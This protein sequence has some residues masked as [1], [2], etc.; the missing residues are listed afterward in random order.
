MRNTRKEKD[1]YPEDINNKMKVL[2]FGVGSTGKR[3]YDEVKDYYEVVGFLDNE[4]QR[5]GEK[6]EDIEILGNANIVNELVY[7][8]IIVASLPGLYGIRDTL[9]ENG[10][11][12][13]KIDISFCQTQ[14]EARINFLNDYAK[15]KQPSNLAVAEGGVFQ[16]EFAK[17]INKNFPNADLYLFD[18]FEGFDKR[19]IA[20]ENENNFSN[21]PVGHTNNTS[22]ELVKEKLQFPE[23][24][25]FRKGFFP[26]TAQ[27]L[28]NIE[29]QFVNLDF[30]LFEPTLEGIRF[31]YPRMESK[32][33][34]LIHDYYN[35][36]YLG[37][38]KAIE[39]FEREIGYSLYKM[40]IGDHC[41]IAVIKE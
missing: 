16:G 12:V 28:E 39:Q 4:Q 26:E 21:Q 40:P 11:E 29:F 32:S 23:K 38:R 22:I 30:D 3:I 7:D 20:V 27:G 37:V 10:V 33:V 14:V 15:T 36:G 8:K 6:I 25:I 35:I 18:T 13:S 24:A 19:D 41:S 5:W 2:I 1:V 34:I 17:H 9:I 31:F